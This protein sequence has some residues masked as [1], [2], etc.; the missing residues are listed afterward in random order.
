MADEDNGVLTFAPTG[1]S[2]IVAGL[3]T[4]TVPLANDTNPGTD[5]FGVVTT[6]ATLLGVL[7]ATVRDV[8][9]D[10]TGGTVSDGTVPAGVGLTL[11]ASSFAAVSGLGRQAISPDGVNSTGLAASLTRTDALETLV[12]PFT[13]VTGDP[14]GAQVVLIGQIVAIRALFPGDVDQNGVVNG[15]DISQIASN[16]LSIGAPG[17]PGDA[18]YNGVV[19]GLDIGLISSNWLTGGGSGTDAAP[20]PEPSTCILAALGGFALLAWRRRCA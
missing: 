18:D 2:N 12:L 11:G 16:W 10:L 9:M 7:T 5:N 6:K 4:N 14:T 8:T 17:I 13:R 15:L 19:N 20:V 3:N 1:G